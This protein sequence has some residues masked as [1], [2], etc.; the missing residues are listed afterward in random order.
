MA[1]SRNCAAKIP[2]KLEISQSGQPEAEQLEPPV[3][4]AKS[5]LGTVVTNCYRVWSGSGTDV[6]RGVF[7][8][9][10]I[11]EIIGDPL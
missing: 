10:V 6:L 5:A 8:N 11:F 1:Q 9:T 4:Y 7:D 2:G 3:F